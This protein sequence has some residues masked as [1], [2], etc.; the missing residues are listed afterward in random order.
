MSCQTDSATEY[1]LLV[2]DDDRNV[3]DSLQRALELSGFAVVT[4]SDGVQAI[5]SCA[6]YEPD[7]VV[8]DIEIPRV[9]GMGVIAALRAAD[10]DVPICV[11]SAH[12]TPNDR[13]VGLEA[14]ADDYLIKPFV[15]GE[16]TARLRALL[17]RRAD[18]PNAD[19][20]KSITIGSLHIDLVGWRVYLAGR[21]IRLTRR[22]HELLTA[23]ATHHG[24]VQSRE[25]L[26]DAVWGYSF[27]TD[28]NVV[29][30]FVSYL[31]RKLETEGGPRIIHTVRGIGYVLRAD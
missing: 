30:V 5:R 10:N 12:N 28:T 25:Q 3:R 27:V 18:R 20:V 23:L 17:R 1:R 9:N 11:L 7:A 16:L 4:A 14:G 6:E 24:V 26:L 21:E 2:V 31:R 22:E 13:I 15:F 29:D 19:R 8:L